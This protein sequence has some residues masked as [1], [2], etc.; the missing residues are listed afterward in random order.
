M[1]TIIY[2]HREYREN[3]C[4]QISMFP[5]CLML[6]DKKFFNKTDRKAKWFV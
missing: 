3:F 6:F 4:M 1:P 5:V 2:Q